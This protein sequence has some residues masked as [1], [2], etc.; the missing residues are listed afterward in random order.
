[1]GD[2][3]LRATGYIPANAAVDVVGDALTVSEPP[4]KLMTGMEVSGY[5]CS[6]GADFD[7]EGKALEH[8]REYN[9]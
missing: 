3:Q 7:S 1:M 6:C 9:E 8:Y 5:F 2:H 4:Q